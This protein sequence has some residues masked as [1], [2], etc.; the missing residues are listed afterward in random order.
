MEFV[1]IPTYILYEIN[2]GNINLKQYICD[3]LKNNTVEILRNKICKYQELMDE[4]GNRFLLDLQKL[5][6]QNNLFLEAGIR[7][8]TD[9]IHILIVKTGTI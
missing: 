5:L 1:G 3:K 7:N 2:K 6:M 8:L 4:E 9:Y